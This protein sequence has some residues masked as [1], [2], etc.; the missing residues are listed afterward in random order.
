[1]TT[2]PEWPAVLDQPAECAAEVSEIDNARADKAAE[3]SHVSPV[4]STG[5]GSPES[6]RRVAVS[7]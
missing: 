5:D 4:N 1:M 7:R 6:P 2:S 3:S